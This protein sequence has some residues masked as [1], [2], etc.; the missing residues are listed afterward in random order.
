MSVRGTFNLRLDFFEELAQD[1]GQKAANV[2]K[3]L[4]AALSDGSGLNQVSKIYADNFSQVQS[5]NTDLDLNPGLTGAFG[6]VLFTTLKGIIVFA[7][8]TN[9]GNLILGNVTNG[10]VAPFGAATHSQA[11]SPGG[12]YANLNPSATGWTVT[13][14]TQD[15]LRI[16]SAATSGTYTGS[17]IL[18]GT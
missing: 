5:V 12:V 3:Q 7:D 4:L 6:T 8:S 15:L 2:T 9:P 14:G 1:M 17:V 16:A 11:V 18:L 13:A 10:I